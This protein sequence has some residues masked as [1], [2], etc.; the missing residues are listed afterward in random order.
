MK[1]IK[2][3]T[4]KIGAGKTTLI[5]T[6][7]AAN[8]EVRRALY[9]GQL[10]RKKFGAGEMA[11]DE[12]PAAPESTEIFVREKI[13]KAIANLEQGH[14]L[15]IDGFPRKPSQVRWIRE[16]FWHRPNVVNEMVYVL[17]DEKTRTDRVFVR[18]RRDQDAFD[19]MKKRLNTESDNILRVMEEI[20]YLK[21]PITVADNSPISSSP[22]LFSGRAHMKDCIDAE[23]VE[24]VTFDHSAFDLRKMFAKHA[25]MNDIALRKLGINTKELY[26]EAKGVNKLPPTDQCVQWSRK[27]VEKAIEE[28]NELLRELPDNWW[29]E[30]DANVRKARVE[31]IDAWHFMMSASFSLGMDA[32]M[33][34]ETYYEKRKVNLQRWAKGYKKRNKGE[35]RDD[36]HIGVAHGHVEPR[37][38]DRTS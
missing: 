19:L 3:V 18:D 27:Y 11:K 33:F 8:P 23:E 2:W 20:N 21:M 29:T 31:L 1:I 34:A 35:T 22:T 30:D 13:I 26:C 32:E 36:L 37:I 7:C 9:I 38:S 16:N 28:L 14:T 15:F 4:G 17:C 6:R 12:N 10:C 24:E 25:I 5:S